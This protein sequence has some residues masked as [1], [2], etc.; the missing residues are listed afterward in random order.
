MKLEPEIP[1]KSKNAV[2]FPEDVAIPETLKIHRVSMEN[3]F[4]QQA[5][6][7]A[8]E[9]KFEKMTVTASVVVKNGGI[10]G[11]G[12]NG[13]GW[14]Q[15]HQTCK[16]LG[17]KNIGKDYEYCPGCHPE[18]HSERVALRQAQGKLLRQTR[19]ATAD[20]E[21]YM[22]GHWWSCEPC[23]RA[24]AAADITNMFLL[25]DGKPL[26]DRNASGQAGRRDAFEKLWKQ[27]L[28]MS[29]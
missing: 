18:N 8:V 17:S 11:E 25:E 4:M 15:K 26:F 14:H 24:V 6:K 21:I 1:Q 28:N 19:K 5:F 9:N 22:Y 29:S 2:G 12:I 20:E 7:L 27:K 3:P 10:I 13:N 23:M 16:R